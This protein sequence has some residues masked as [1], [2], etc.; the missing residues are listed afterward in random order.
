MPSRQANCTVLVLGGLLAGLLAGRL[1]AAA[2]KGA[3]GLD[4]PTPDALLRD[5][6][7][8]RPDATEGPFTVD[9]GRVQLEMDLVNRADGESGG[10]RAT[11]WGVAPFNLRLGVRDNF[12]VGLFVAPYTRR[13]ER[14][15]G[16]ARETVAGFGDVTLRAKVNFWG[17]DGGETALGL[18]TDLKLP[19]AA[20]GLGSGAVAGTILLPA[21][22]ELARG[23]DLGAMTGMDFVRSEAG[24]RR[25]G[26]INSVTTGHGISKNLAG[27]LEIASETGA[28]APV[29][30]FDA[31]LTLKLNADTQLDVG[32]QFGLSRAAADTVVFTGLTRRY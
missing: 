30:T 29:T 8:D 17:N 21:S 1:P 22:I 5:L 12:E 4:R 6:N 16:R 14:A 20:A 32:A 27:Y 24:R 10:G 26:W 11:E 23:W 28:D 7:S 2:D 3:F 15:P 13:T 19:T 9:A 25:C 18:I 31:G